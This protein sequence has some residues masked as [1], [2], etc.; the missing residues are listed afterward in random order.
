MR[1]I[2]LS[3]ACMFI[4]SASALAQNLYVTQT[5][6]TETALPL[7]GISKIKFDSGNMIAVMTSGEDQTY[8][9]SS[10]R[11][12]TF[13]EGTYVAPLP[14]AEPSF[15]YSPAS[16]SLTLSGKAGSVVNVYSISG[17]RVLTTVQTISE[18]TIDLSQLPRGI[19]VVE[20]EGKSSKF[21]R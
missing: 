9:L 5:S 1:R 20:A 6:G 7:S 18:Q 13:Q 19:Y 2:A 10:V 4:L 12:L 3:I 11:A 21:V 8:A 17:Q 15:S 16:H 14:V